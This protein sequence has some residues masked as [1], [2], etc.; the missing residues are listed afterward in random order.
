MRQRQKLAC[1]NAPH[2]PRHALPHRY[3]PTSRLVEGEPSMGDALATV[4]TCKTAATTPSVRMQT[5]T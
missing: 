1:L 4:T 2:E 5:L 3:V